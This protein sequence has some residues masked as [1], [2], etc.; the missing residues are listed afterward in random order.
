MLHDVVWLVVERRKGIF[1]M[2]ESIALEFKN[3]SK[4]YQVGK[5]KVRALDHANFKIEAEKLIVILGPSGSGKSTTLNLIGGMDKVTSGNI[6][7]FGEDITKFT[8]KDLTKYRRKI[9]GFVFQF[10]NLI[11]SLNALENV[12]IVERLGENP[13]EAKEIIKAVGLGD[14]M[15]H[16]PAELS[17]GELQRL[18]IARALCKNPEILLCD[19]PTGA[20]D[21]ET[22]ENIL[23]V[24]QTMAKKYKKTVIIVTHNASIAQCADITIKIKDGSIEKIE[25]NSH[26]LPVREVQW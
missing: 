22:G 24:L 2:E 12:D 21:S 17:G 18:S 19:E 8:E 15:K 4:I 13:L 3:V 7:V 25:N 20:L 10:Y 9:I 16:F 5:H 11:P 26:P 1:I 14:R 23:E 6:E